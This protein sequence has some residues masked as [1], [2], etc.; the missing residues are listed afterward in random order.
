MKLSWLLSLC[1]LIVLAS[2]ARARETMSLSGDWSFRT[3]PKDVGRNEKWFS[4][5]VAFPDKI[6]VPGA[7]NAQGVG[8]PA[9]A[10]FSGYSGVAWY[11]KT[12][13]IPEGLR[14][15]GIYIN[16]GAVHRD[17]DV[18]V[19]GEHVGSHEGYITPFR[20]E[21][22]PQVVRNWTADVVVRV[23]SQRH[24]NVDPLYSC[25]D[26]MDMGE[27][28]WGGIYR[29]VWL[30]SVDKSWISNIYV[31]P[32]IDSG[33]AEVVVETDSHTLYGGS[34][35]PPP[36]FHFEA[37]I[38]DRTGK[39]VG[40]GRSN[41]LL[42]SLQPD[43]AMVCIDK[44]KLWSPKQP[45]LYTV[46]VRLYQEGKLLD[47]VSERFGMRELSVEGNQILLNGKPIFLRGFGDD[48]VFP[49]TIAPP[50]DKSVYLSRLKT[51]KE[52]GFN[53]I[54]C[55]SW[56]PPKEYLDAAD[57]VGIL[58]Q[59]EFPIAYSEFYNA[60]TPE[61]QAFYQ[62]QWRDVI[63]TNRNHPSVAT[64][65]MANE[66]WD[67]FDL[68]QSMYLAAKDLDSTTLVIDSDGI[69]PLKPGQ[70]SRATLDFLPVL[71]DE[72]KKIGFN[73]G[74]YEMGQWK[75]EKPVLIHEMGNYG[76]FPDLAQEMLFT[77]GVRPFWLSDERTL[78]E[79]KGVTGQLAQWKANSD[80]LQAVVLK[81]NIEAARSSRGISGYDQWLLQDYW[82]GSNGVLDMFYRPK[83]ISASEFRKFNSPTVL[84]MKSLKRSYWMGETAKVSL[85][86]SRYEDA[87]TTK[88]KLAWKLMDSG[89]TAGSGVKSIAKIS[90]S[91]LQPLT[92]I[93]MKMPTSG[94]ARKVTLL[95]ELSDANGK[96]TNDWD[97]WIYPSAKATVSN[98]VCIAGLDA[99]AA[100]Y[101]KARSVG[102]SEDTKN[103]SLLI[104][105]RLT[106]ESIDYMDSGGKVLLIGAEGSLPTV[107]SSYKPYWWLGGPTDS[108]AGTVVD[109]AHS[110]LAGMPKESWCNL[111]YYHLLTGSTAVLM[112]DLPQRIRPII[113]SID[114]P[115]LMR[116]KA[117]LFEAGVGKGKLLVA[118]MN[119]TDA[120]GAGDPAAVYLLDRLIRYGLSTSFAPVGELPAEYLR[121]A[122]P[123]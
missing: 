76:T 92:D 120:I 103:C 44:P 14:G 10:L 116:S 2:S 54:R 24:A 33:V 17:A 62:D 112:D 84:L 118:S 55:H 11:R 88:A 121:S 1:C 58:V 83:G 31:R 48:C 123:K 70:L 115:S 7:W 122:A 78:A 101:P 104:S 21:I 75:P 22:T 95:V 85:L 79:K 19:N 9:K 111:D 90:S 117:H 65:S 89:K 57:E 60:G 113:S 94:V 98:S 97:F 26:V 51:A 37:E 45:Y 67:G 50:A 42:P 107:G 110:A 99:V 53:Y 18:W 49:N 36:E 25:M 59:P 109:A 93:A 41:P 4:G 114:P 47:T 82:T 63:R 100:L 96:Q 39:I 73:D 46:V 87:A 29:D 56:I 72:W 106:K 15:K 3:D 30:D 20:L 61:L 13:D 6:R 5:S 52:Y 69:W 43:Y 86:V 81:T 119:F 28:S 102:L 40:S 68:A 108:N 34:P 74:K 12:V 32:H 71:F 27:L 77:G 8:E 38:L 91:G 23:D 35:E 105:S 16:F 66:M 80:R 64:W